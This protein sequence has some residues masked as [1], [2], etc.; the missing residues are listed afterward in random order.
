[1]APTY[2]PGDRVL[3]V[4]RWR[5]LRPGDVVLARDPRDP[6][7]WLLKRCTQC[8][9][10]RVELR[11]DNPDASTDSRTFGAVPRRS[12]RWLVV[13]PRPPATTVG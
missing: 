3:V 5:P 10:Q 7:R 4:R 11:G 9:G 1:M 2:R 8:G 6:G 12:V 13:G